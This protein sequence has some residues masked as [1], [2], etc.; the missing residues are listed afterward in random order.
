MAAPRT[1]S[2]GAPRLPKISTQFRN[3]FTGKPA[4]VIHNTTCVRSIAAR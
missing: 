1:P 3:M 4:S 2:S